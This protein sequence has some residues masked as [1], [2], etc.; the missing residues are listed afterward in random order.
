MFCPSETVARF[1]LVKG[2][3]EYELSCYYKYGPSFGRG[4]IAAES[5]GGADGL[6]DDWCYCSLGVSYEDG[7]GQGD[8]TF[9]GERD[10]VPVEIEVYACSPLDDATL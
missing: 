6:F 9:T 3:E 1:G 2:E 7:L 5:S 4:D 10:F 8:A